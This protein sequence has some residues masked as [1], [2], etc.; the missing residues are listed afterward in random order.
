MGAL[1]RKYICIPEPECNHVNSC[2]TKTHYSSFS[3][4]H[5]M[6]EALPGSCI[7]KNTTKMLW[8][9]VTEACLILRASMENRSGTEI[10]SLFSPC[11]KRGFYQ[12]KLP[13]LLSDL[14]CCQTFPKYRQQWRDCLPLRQHILLLLES[15]PDFQLKFHF[16]SCKWV[17]SSHSKYFKMFGLA[18][19]YWSKNKTG[20]LCLIFSVKIASFSEANET[21]QHKREEP[22]EI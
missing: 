7:T 22:L 18:K 3:L 21:S 1:I 11:L 19:K 4:A 13:E 2:M 15:F 6:L 17:Y 5:S 12:S 10:K 9:D 20:H 14:S 8:T 16:Q